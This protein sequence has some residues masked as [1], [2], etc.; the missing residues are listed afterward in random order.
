MTKILTL[1]IIYDSKRILLEMKKRGFGK[2]RWN[3]FGGKVKDNESI[4]NATY[5]ELEEEIG[6]KATDA[7]KRGVLTFSF[8][9]ELEKLEVHLFTANKLEG[10]PAELDKMKPEWF[11]HN[12]IPYPKMWSDGPLWLPPIHKGKNVNGGFHFDSPEGNKIKY[13]E[14]REVI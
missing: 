13:Y 12:E 9:G 8:D 10:N 2:D 5:R 7:K 6:I 1:C 3:G 11:E 14:I 4:E